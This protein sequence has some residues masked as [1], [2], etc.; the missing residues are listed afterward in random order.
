M[1]YPNIIFF[2][3]KKYSYIDL[4]FEGNKISLLCNVNITS[5][6]SY[7]N[8]LYNPDYHLLV[9]FGDIESEYYNDVFD[10]ISERM[11]KRW[12]HYK[13]IP[14]VNTFNNNV[15]YCFINNVTLNHS[16]TR[17]TFSVF[18][19]C[20]NS[21]EKIHRVYNSLKEQIFK[22]WEWVIL[23]D[24]PDENHFNY[25]KELLLNDNRIRLYKRAKNSGNIGNVKNEACSLCRGKYLLEL[26]HDDE[27]LPCLLLDATNVFESDKDIGFIYGDFTNIYENYRNF[28][29]GN[30]FSLGYGGYYM[31]KW[32]DKWV[33]VC[34]SPNINNITLSNIV[35]VPNH[36]RIWRKDKL[37]EIGNYSEF[38]PISD[39]YE[40]LLRT[41]SKLK[42]AKIHK[43][44]YVQYMNENN[45]NFSYIRNS[46]INRLCKSHIQPQAYINYNINEIMKNVNAF[47]DEKFM[48]DHI[49]IWKRE[50]Y[51]HLY[52]NAI[53]NVDYN[54][55]Y[56][57]IGTVAFMQ[58]IDKIN[59]LYQN[60]KNDFILLDN[61]CN[62]EDL[63]K[64]LDSFNFD[65]MKCY[66]MSDVTNEQLINYFHLIY[67]SIDNYEII[68]LEKMITPE[69]SIEKSDM[70]KKVYNT[71][72]C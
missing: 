42:V 72:Q 70:Y 15:N 8:N 16:I 68:S 21:Y 30:M 58:N 51:I 69:Y 28:S 5:D 60:I 71:N 18:T 22:D 11:K 49:Q 54:K 7:L 14:D 10:I 2:R 26:D 4:F 19:T 23:D 39:D 44:G 3:Y 41:C 56:C 53:I 67:K 52:S 17:V 50:N 12:V 59:E 63:C 45:N 1:K 40:L 62:C 27:I 48:N 32:K 6:K 46:E 61:K 36:P 29:Y 37:N 55:I 34:S 31:Q 24:S 38:L 33:Y 13:E 20:Y 66:S 35:S 9:T 65:R 47:E 64:L 57:I 25:L 43:L